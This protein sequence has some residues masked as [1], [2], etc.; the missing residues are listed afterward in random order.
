MKL[1]DDLLKIKATSSGGSAEMSISSINTN[2]RNLSCD[3]VAWLTDCIERYLPK[4][5]Y[6]AVSYQRDMK[7]LGM[8]YEIMDLAN[9]KFADEDAIRNATPHFLR[10]PSDGFNRAK[11]A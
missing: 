8:L 6:P 11:P 10:G 7:V 9:L 3:Q 2:D 1:G 4:D 5:G